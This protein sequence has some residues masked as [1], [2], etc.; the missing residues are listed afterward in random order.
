LNILSSLPT[1]GD[2][3]RAL[4][5]LSLEKDGLNATY[6]QAM[7]RI[8]SQGKGAPDLAKRTLS[9]I[10]HSTRPLSTLELIHALAVRADM[11][12]LDEE[13]IPGIDR[14][15]SI[16]VGL[17]TVDEQSG[18]VRLVHYTAQVYLEL[19]QTQQLWFPDAQRQISQAC[20]SYLS[21]DAFDTGFCNTDQDFEAR[22]QHNPFYDYAARNWGH[23]VH[24]APPDLQISV[25]RFLE[26]ETKV[27][28]SNQAMMVAH[29][30]TK[31][32]YSQ[33]V[34]KQV[35]GVHLA[36]WFGL[37]E[38]TNALL[39]RGYLFD[40]KDT[41][42]STPMARAAARGHAMVVKLLLAT[43]A[44]DPNSQDK[45]NATPL[46]WAAKGG[47]ED[48]VQV[49]LAEATIEP[50]LKDCDG[51][52][53]LQDAADEGCVGTVK[54]LLGAAGVDINSKNRFGET[55]LL[56][57]ASKGHEEVVELLLAAGADKESRSEFEHTPFSIAVARG[58]E[59]VVKLMLAVDG[60]DPDSRYS[61]NR[62]PLHMA[63]LRG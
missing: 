26:D 22:L 63:A 61:E 41:N 28:S 42:G 6:E 62:T 10:I 50:D 21:L 11:P 15:Q 59:E 16:C 46:L 9:W 8:E 44:V 33:V 4:R 23:H 45:Y 40:C 55:T 13:Y 5:N 53:P 20:V 57:A 47:H 48:V 2:I 52:T 58:Q 29:K 49:L 12:K 7:Q 27:A 54:L 60:I 56:R 43:A 39:K 3:K 51:V 17:I 38:I 24:A 34:P 30:S 25:L 14:L 31:G 19:E 18:I 36:A 37:A 32:D 35:T 1:K